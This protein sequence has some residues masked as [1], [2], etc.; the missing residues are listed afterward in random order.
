MTGTETATF[1]EPD[2]LHQF[3][4]RNWWAIGIGTVLMFVATV[5]YAA[6]FVDDEGRDLPPGAVALSEQRRAPDRPGRAPELERRSALDVPGLV[7]RGEGHEAGDDE[8]HA[9]APKRRWGIGV[10]QPLPDPGEVPRAATPGK[11]SGRQ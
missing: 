1:L 2:Q 3:R 6:A 5:A 9:Q 7:A 10:H 4:K 11:H 8:G